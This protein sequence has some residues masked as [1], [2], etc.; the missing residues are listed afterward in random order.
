LLDQ[1]SRMF[2]KLL[3]PYLQG[4]GKTLVK[5]FLAAF[6]VRLFLMPI[7]VHP[8]LVN[9]GL[10]AVM[11]SDRGIWLPSPDSPLYYYLYAGWLKFFEP[12][13][14]P[15]GIYWDLSSMINFGTDSYQ[16]GTA[17]ILRL[18][19]PQVY[20][21]LF[22]SKSLYLIPDFLAAL[23]ILRVFDKPREGLL[24]FKL[25]LLNPITIFVTYAIGQFDIF[26]AF[27]LVLSLVA[28]YKKKYI[29]AAGFIGLGA[30]FKVFL[31]ALL[32]L[33]LLPLLSD[34]T[35]MVKIRNALVS[36]TIAVLP[37][38]VSN[39]VTKLLPVYTAGYNN[40]VNYSP[41]FSFFGL[42]LNR[43]NTLT[44]NSGF[45]DYLYIF[46]LCYFALLIFCYLTRAYNYEGYWSV[47]LAIF[48]LYYTFSFFHP[49]WY[50][51]IQPI[52]VIAIVKYRKLLPIYLLS[53][54]G[55][56]GY[57]LYFDAAATTHLLAPLTRDVYSWVTPNQILASYGLPPTSVIGIFKTLFGA[58]CI[59]IVVYTLW[60]IYLQRKLNFGENTI[61]ASQS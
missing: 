47:G 42:F 1:I 45:D 25:W 54:V 35:K 17:F 2:Q 9:N 18:S 32:P 50:L 24:A 40:L 58:A 46:V 22:I 57:L 53:I 12:V 16:G 27:F 8:D 28:V 51:W 60:K 20:N 13:I 15:V 49:Q 11:L 37:F 55:F 59:S 34:K 38:L 10:Q 44:T 29:Y 52:I 48:L 30:A 41:T 39:L 36:V 23:I 56:V 43:T 14:S 5:W 19:D 31:I 21:F 4:Y 3:P 6:L 61:E 33:I 7:L 26:V